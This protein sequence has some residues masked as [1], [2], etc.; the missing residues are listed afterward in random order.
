MYLGDGEN[1]HNNVNYNIID[2]AYSLITEEETTTK[3][4]TTPLF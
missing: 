1:P 2:W 3:T 4:E